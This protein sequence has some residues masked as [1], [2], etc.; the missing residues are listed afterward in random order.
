MRDCSEWRSREMIEE[1]DKQR[2]LEL[3]KIWAEDK[4]Q[5][6]QIRA[7]LRALEDAFKCWD[8]AGFAGTLLE[9]KGEL[10]AFAI[11]SMM[12][13]DMADVHFEKAIYNCKGSAQMINRETAAQL[14]GKAK[15]INR[16]QDIGVPGLRHAKL[17]YDPE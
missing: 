9:V 13:D 12:T 14:R 10:I 6:E 11:H 15:W 3:A 7:D 17:S 2:V 4:I 8:R 5:N 1:R 16:E